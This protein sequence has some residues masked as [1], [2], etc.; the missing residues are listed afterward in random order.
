MN[1]AVRIIA[2]LA[3][4]SG[5][6]F[7]QHHHEMEPAADADRNAF[8]AGVALVAAS[9]ETQE[10]GGNYQGI[11]PSVRWSRPRY[12]A[13]VTAG[14]YRLAENGAEV[15][16]L[17]DLTVHG[18]ATLVGDRRTSAGVIAGVTAP[19]G[20]DQRGMGMGHTMV[21]PALYGATMISFVEVVATAGYS[22]A[23][24]ADSHHDHGPWPLVEPMLMSEISWSGGGDVRVTPDFRAGGRLSG[25]IPVGGP[26]STRV[27]GAL[28]A[29]WRTGRVESSAELQGGLAGDPFTVRGVVSTALSF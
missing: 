1:V 6:A 29:S 5:T 3:L 15:Y 7:A 13:A 23:I 4:A 14:L 11:L 8:G 25:G 20:N 12:G 22:R 17:G 2:C 26:G 21:M 28:R 18:Q 10:Y 27:V 19:I 16:G 24:G 9:F